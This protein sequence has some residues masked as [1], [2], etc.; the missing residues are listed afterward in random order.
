[1]LE[2]IPYP[3][4]ILVLKCLYIFFSNQ[5]NNQTNK[6]Q[7][8]FIL[9]LKEV[10]DRADLDP[11]ETMTEVWYEGW[12]RVNCV[13]G[14]WKSIFDREQPMP[15]SYG[16]QRDIKHDTFKSPKEDPCV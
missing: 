12:S 13:N 16:R 4:I 10:S 6:Y 11:K 3:K 9:M 14:G 1:M 7:L 8:W 5:I 15:R 2:I